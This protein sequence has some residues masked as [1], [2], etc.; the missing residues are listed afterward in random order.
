MNGEMATVA[1]DTPSVSA[2]ASRASVYLVASATAQ[3]ASLVTFPIY[4]RVLGPEQYGVLALLMAFMGLGKTAALA[5]TNTALIRRYSAAEDEETRKD[6]VGSALGYV[7]ASGAAANL[8]ALLAAGVASQLLLGSGEYS[9]VFR[10]AV[11]A[12]SIELVVETLMALT[13]SMERAQLYVTITTI[14]VAGYVVMA[15]VFLL[16]LGLGVEG[17]VL[18]ILIGNTLALTALVVGLRGHLSLRMSPGTVSA[19]VG[20]G[21]G[22]LP[23]NLASWA[24]NV[25]DRYMI[26]GYMT[27]TDV[28][29]YSAAYRVASLVQVG[30]VLPFHQAWLPFMFRHARDARGPEV[31]A[32]VSRYFAAVGLLITVILSAVGRPILVLFAGS[33]F[34]A[35]A[36][37]IPIVSVGVLLGGSVSVVSP[38]LM[39]SGKTWLSS[40]IFVLG[41]IGNVLLNVLLI[42]RFGIGGAAWATLLTYGGVAVGH[43]GVAQ[44]HYRVP[45]PYGRLAVLTVIATAWA[46]GMMLA[47]DIQPV[48]TSIV[49]RVAA[50][51]LFAALLVAAGIVS[52]RELRTA[53]STVRSGGVSLID[54][55]AAHSYAGRL[56]RR[57]LKRGERALIV[58]PSALAGR[59]RARAVEQR[60]ASLGDAA[61][62]GEPVLVNVPVLP[63]ENREH[64]VR[65]ARRVAAGERCVLGRVF[66]AESGTW[67]ADSRRG[68]TWPRW[69][70][71]RIDLGETLDVADPK[72][73]WELSRCHHVVALAQGFAIG[74][75]ESLAMAA[76]SQMGD[77]MRSNPLG[78]GINWTV[79]MEVAIRAINWVAA[80]DLLRGSEAWTSE[81]D[82]RVASWLVAHAEFI[83]ENI[84]DWGARTQN[85]FVADAT[86]LAVLGTA[87][88]GVDARA[89]RWARCGREGLE[90]SIREQVYADGVDFENSVSY[91]RL[92]TEMVTIGAVALARAGT[93][94]RETSLERLARMFDYVRA[95]TRPDGTAPSVGDSDDGRILMLDGYLGWD[96]ST[97]TYLLPLGSREGDEVR[98]AWGEWLAVDETLG[99]RAGARASG[100]LAFEDGGMYLFRTGSAH[101]TVNA[102]RTGVHGHGPHRHNDPLSFTLWAVGREF[103][104][105]RGTFCYGADTSRRDL[106]RSSDAHNVLV[107]DD[108]EH[109]PAAG[110]FRLAEDRISVDVLTWDAG[111]QIE[112]FRASCGSYL[113]LDDPVAWSREFVFDRNADSFTVHDLIQ[114]DGVHDYVVRF[115]FA[116]GV[117]L[118]ERSG[119]AMAW[120]ADGI[121]VET[122]APTGLH[123]RVESTMVSPSWCVERSADVL[124]LRAE[125]YA[126]TLELTTRFSWGG[127]ERG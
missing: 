17:A 72:E 21:I 61:G 44:R 94:L 70:W 116:P 122:T 113:H 108:Q 15:V 29:Q 83:E 81:W 114:A 115:H 11:A 46:Q 47:G 33:E 56:V 18:G 90:R 57:T 12:V 69:Y 40:T 59:S 7:V 48:W 107:V 38:G 50:V 121:T 105:D 76:V 126:G 74:R 5:G 104:V 93:A 75:E 6:T 41:A 112:R 2:L 32:R 60:A 96:P 24:L 55:W 92:V 26:R 127:V 31:V 85:H 39:V 101:L 68:Y 117:K 63:E 52:G 80:R 77:W 25:A 78:F 3:L 49:I 62:T 23:A 67:H 91:H 8:I 106:Y 51:A 99:V 118:S 89:E 53:L 71:R 98:S 28:G 102:S 119:E 22:L 110:V 97:H 37:I 125:R 34:A 66:S 58:L 45:A 27:L 73:P 65:D 86:G 4:A 88:Q 1:D 10:L 109:A 87:L 124:V 64:Y 20:F 82:A 54:T 84:E 111:G 19:L 13:R 36:V 103:V 42:P 100:S 30:F 95:Y 14:R 79:P 123:A 16:A 9:S 120:M 43:I 35:A